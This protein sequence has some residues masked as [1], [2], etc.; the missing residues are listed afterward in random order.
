M[1]EST[2][3]QNTGLQEKYTGPISMGVVYFLGFML[4]ALGNN[5]GE[6]GFQFG[7]GAVFF[8]I[9]STPYFHH[10]RK[11][12]SIWIFFLWIIHFFAINGF[13]G[14]L[15]SGKKE[16]VEFTDVLTRFLQQCF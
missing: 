1:S 7:I 11:A 15:L 4:M 3:I 2:A 13:A 14:F 16:G 10:T 9:V 8:F 5:N 12:G 6:G